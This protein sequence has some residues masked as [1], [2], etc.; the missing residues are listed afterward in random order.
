MT[1]SIPTKHD[2]ASVSMPRLLDQ[3]DLAKYLK[4]SISWCE[5]ARFIGDGPR[6]IKIGRNVRYRAE[7]I[8][9]WIAENA[10]TST[11]DRVAGNE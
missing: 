9:D 10:R 7:D 4:K 1:D 8:L 11:S 3:N 5:R 2:L 6:F